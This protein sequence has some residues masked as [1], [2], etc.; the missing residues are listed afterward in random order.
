MAVYEGGAR[1]AATLESVLR[2]TLSDFELLVVDDGSTDDTPSIL[3]E[4]AARDPRVR[5]ITQMNQ[6]LT[7]ALI[8]GCSAA[9][10][11][12]IARQDAGDTSMPERFAQQHEALTEGVVLV[13]CWT[14]TIAPG[15]ETM[16]ETNADGR[17][18]RASLLRDGVESIRGLTH[19]GTAMFRRD[20]Y[21]AAGGYR[22][23]F[24]F[25]QDLD[26]WIRLARAGRIAIVPDV[27]Y[28]ATWDIRSISAN[29]RADQVAL[30]EISIALRDGGDETTLL[31][32]ASAIG[33]GEQTR[34][35]IERDDG[36]AF[37]FIASC[38]RRNGDPRFRRY[39]RAALRRDP[40]SLRTWML[41]IR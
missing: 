31:A 3:C 10:A 14:R 41:L 26:L 33:R 5:V 8:A 27:L 7:R 40:F 12:V 4:Y 9:R 11:P 6:G 23:A 34:R 37:H 38:L 32:R 2:Q 19:H 17:E 24:R 28:E 39:A 29:Q 15:G 36:R 13:S 18:A 22:E 21:L 1:L 30:A 25:A 20:A 16:F 35:R